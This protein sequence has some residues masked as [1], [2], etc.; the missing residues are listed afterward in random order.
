MPN[1][2]YNLRSGNNQAG[3]LMSTA[4]LFEVRRV[5][6]RGVGGKREFA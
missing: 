1:K 2:Q 6:R 3:G 4:R 5:G